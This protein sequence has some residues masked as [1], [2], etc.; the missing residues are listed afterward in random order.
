MS[1]T[2]LL[3]FVGR[4][5]NGHTYLY[6]ILQLERFDP[7]GVESAMKRIEETG[8]PA[9]LKSHYHE[10]SQKLHDLDYKAAGEALTRIQNIL[11]DIMG[12]KS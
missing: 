1:T 5:H 9:E 11:H 3:A 12:K 8:L 6:H 2:T 4:Q 10:L 7:G